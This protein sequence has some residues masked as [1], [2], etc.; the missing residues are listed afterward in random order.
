MRDYTPMTRGGDLET[1][2]ADRQELARQIDAL[3]ALPARPWPAIFVLG[4]EA[5]FGITPA[6]RAA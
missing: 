2:A 4:D 5:V 3:L 1:Q 6:K